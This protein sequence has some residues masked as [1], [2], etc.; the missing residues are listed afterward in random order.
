[1]SRILVAEDNPN[2]CEGI[3]TLLE[4]A[5]FSVDKACNGFEAMQKLRTKKFDV[6]VMDVWMPDM[7]GLDL[8]SLLPEAAQPAKIVVLTGDDRPETLLRAVREKVYQYVVKPFDPKGLV[9]IVRHALETSADTP[10]IEVVSARPEWVELV[11]PC[12]LEVVER[13]ENFVLQLDAGLPKEIRESAGI[14]FREL[15]LNAI[16]WGGRLDP[17]QKVRISC[18]RTSRMLLYRIADPGKGFRFEDLRHA[19]IHN[20]PGQPDAHL[21]AREERGLRPGGFGILLSKNIVDDLLY[22]EAQNEVVFVKY[23]D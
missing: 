20:P 15:L 1:M 11:V 18:L 22:N 10:P 16:E 9:E 8:L 17:S 3:R 7:N 19:A 5:G 21:A 2:Q 23:L 14:A 13:I 6:M 12:S 4:H